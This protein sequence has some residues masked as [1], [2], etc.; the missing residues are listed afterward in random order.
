M[1]TNIIIPCHGRAELAEQTIESLYKNTPRDSFTLHV[2]ADAPDPET[3]AV[4]TN[5]RNRYNFTMYENNEAQ[6]PG[7]CRNMICRL[8]TH[9]KERGQFLYHSDSDIYFMEG[10][11]EA[12][13]KA[14]NALHDEVKLFGA[15][16]H[17][18]HLTNQV[19]ER[20]GVVVHTKDAIAGFTAFMDWE[21]WFRYGPYIEFKGIMGSEDFV[22]CRK[23]VDSGSFVASIY[24][25]KII[26]CGKTNSNGQLATGHER[27]VR[28]EGVKIL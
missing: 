12:L 21:T 24:P 3:T 26:H 4:L 11:L 14:Y 20:D 9:A 28:I 7:W 8:L 15:G 27:M 10:W 2:Y 16:S 17:P 5:L 25:E 22:F 13:I 1:L 23:I 6:G 18:Y 19:L